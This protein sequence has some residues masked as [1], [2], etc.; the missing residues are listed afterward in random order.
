MVREIRWMRSWYRPFF[1]TLAQRDVIE[2]VQISIER[3]DVDE[4]RLFPDA[5]EPRKEVEHRPL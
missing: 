3:T 2:G 5:R 4:V 1:T